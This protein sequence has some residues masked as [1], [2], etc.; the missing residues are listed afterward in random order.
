[1]TVLNNNGGEMVDR[2]GEYP[3]RDIVG[4]VSSNGALRQPGRDLQIQTHTSTGAE[5]RRHVRVPWEVHD[6]QQLTLEVESPGQKWRQV[7]FTLVDFAAGGVGVLVE[8]PLEAG[9]RIRVTF[10]LPSQLGEEGDIAELLPWTALAEVI[11]GREIPEPAH[12][13]VPAHGH[14]PYL[15]GARFGPLE[16]D[17][18]MRLLRALYG[19]LPDG[20]GVEHYRARR[21]GAS[22]NAP[23]TS[24][25]PADEEN[26]VSRYAVL[27]HGKRVAW[28]F[29]S[30]DRARTRAL[31]MHL[32]ET[33]EARQK[34]KEN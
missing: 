1:M 16:D 6:P 29:G 19:P 4:S 27:R 13:H 9:S 14:R 17:A 10:P 33:A 3:A 34:K 25:E 2:D 20:W 28:G 8:E 18:Q 32:D 15:R 5:R 26:T 12:P 21:P 24:G 30:Y 11:H 22:T 31:S 7:P 23:A